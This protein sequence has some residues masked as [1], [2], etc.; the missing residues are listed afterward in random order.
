MGCFPAIVRSLQL[1]LMGPLAVAA[2]LGAA[3]QHA[4]PPAAEEPHPGPIPTVART[5]LGEMPDIDVEAVLAHTRELS[6]DRFEGRLPG[7]D[8]ESL[9]V[10]YLVDQ[11]RRL[12]LKPGNTDGTFIQKVPLVGITADGGPLTL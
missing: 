8:G 6:S 11:F 7:T 5:S 1:R 9:T 4:P 12:G 10:G 3:C 2:A